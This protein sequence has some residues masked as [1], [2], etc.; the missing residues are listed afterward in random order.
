[1]NTV[2]Y[3]HWWTFAVRAV[4]AALFGIAVVTRPDLSPLELSRW[5]GA[6]ALVDGILAVI[7]AVRRF[8]AGN[9]WGDPGWDGQPTFA[10]DRAWRPLVAEGT[11]SVVAGFTVLAW[12]IVGDRALLA[13]I[14]GRFLATA[15]AQALSAD[16]LRL[17][18]VAGAA[19][20]L[21]AAVSAAAGLVLVAPPEAGATDRSGVIGGAALVTAVLLPVIAAALWRQERSVTAPRLAPVRVAAP[22]DGGRVRR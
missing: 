12:P 18:A 15:V 21:I 1:M 20:A 16:R 10:I 4:A 19:M 14:A 11:L 2:L 7:A 8:D 17:S 6:Y 9:P 5:F 22:V 13:A 3:R